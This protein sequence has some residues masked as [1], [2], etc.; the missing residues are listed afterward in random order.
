MP[1]PQYRYWLLTIPHHLFVPYL[2][3][4]F[5]YVRGQLEQ[6][7]ST[8]YLHWQLLAH[9]K[10][11]IT[12]SALKKTFGNSIHAEASRSEAANEYVWKEDTRVP[13]T[14]FELGKLPF[15]RNNHKDWESVL[16]HAKRGQF[17]NIP[18]DILI[19]CY[20][21]I[22]RI[23]QDHLQPTPIER[24]VDVFWG[25]TGTGKSRRAWEEAGIT[26]YP[27]DPNTKFWDGYKGT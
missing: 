13:N 22:R 7:D 8:G 15:Q 17:D 4:D 24:S 5:D 19:R 16:D 2:P 9:S 21:N 12:L 27:K 1:A 26:A 3:P 18:A 23:H 10:R 14:Q 6:G 11:K 25:K 20:S